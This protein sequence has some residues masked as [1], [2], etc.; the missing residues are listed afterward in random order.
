M[1]FFAAFKKLEPFFAPRFKFPMHMV[2]IVLVIAVIGLSA[3]RMLLPNAPRG[4][5]TTMGLGMGAKSLIIIGYQLL[6]EHVNR[7]HKWGS[8]K[9][10]AI[11][12]S[13]EV[14]FWGAVAFMS[15]TANTKTCIGT[16]CALGWVVFVLAVLLSI[17]AKYTAVISIMDW[18]H[19]RKNSTDRGLV[20]AGQRGDSDSQSSLEMGQK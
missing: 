11:L 12:N 5:S 6:T 13:L 20:I 9:A 19:F 14:V 18:Y 1:G 15:L 4:R 16:S 8:L 2:Q 3:A 10:Y 17:L 7:L